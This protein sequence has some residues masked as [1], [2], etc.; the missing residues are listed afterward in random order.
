M[1][2]CFCFKDLAPLDKSGKNAVA[3]STARLCSLDARSRVFLGAAAQPTYP[4]MREGN[5]SQAHN[6][7][8]CT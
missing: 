5:A 7:V 4:S 8:V 3:M 6:V 1:T 2:L